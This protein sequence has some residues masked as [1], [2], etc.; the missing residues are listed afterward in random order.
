MSQC[1]PVVRTL[2]CLH[3]VLL[4]SVSSACGPSALPDFANPPPEDAGTQHDARAQANDDSEDAG[5]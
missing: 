2:A 5:E 4:A 1:N 3:L